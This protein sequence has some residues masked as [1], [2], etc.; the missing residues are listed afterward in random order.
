MENLKKYGVLALIAAFLVGII[1]FYAYDTNKGKLP[2]KTSN[3]QDVVYSV[4]GQD[5]TVDAFYDRLN[6]TTGVS[7]AYRLLYNTVLDESAETT[8][9]M[10]QLAEYNY[11]SI[12][13]NYQSYY[14]EE[15]E[16]YLLSDLK[17]MGYTQVED[18]K[19][20]LI[21]QF[22]LRTLLITY[23][24]NNPDVVEA[25]TKEKS[26]RILSHILVKMEDVEN[27]TDEELAKVKEVEDALA[28]GK[29]FAEVATE[30]SD[31]TG[32]AIDG[33]NLGFSDAD[34]S[35]VP[36]FLEAGLALKTGE[37]SEWVAS[38]YGYHM[39][40]CIT[41]DYDTLKEED[42]FLTAITTYNPSLQSEAIWEAAEKLG[43]DF[44]K[45]PELE[46]DLKAYMGLE[47]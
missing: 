9:E 12:I 30:Y 10:E 16:T 37:T 20:Y 24:D 13:S 15:Y 14:N 4:D 35:Y 23:M 39:I 26:P 29:D 22:K 31:D 34:T 28:E 17:N 43:L 8:E 32:S 46:A 42:D 1:G 45:S 19:T 11:S 3:G 18:L 40:T 2:G 6:E 5:I 21:Q 27:P 25:Y 33:G 38:T 36:E 47:D 41:T 44:S 7:A